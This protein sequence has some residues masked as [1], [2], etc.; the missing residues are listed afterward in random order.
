MEVG[1]LCSA[2]QGARC[3]LLEARHNL[4][5]LGAAWCFRTEG[6]R[7]GSRQPIRSRG[8]REGRRPDERPG[9]GRRHLV[10]NSQVSDKAARRAQ[11]RAASSARHFRM[12]FLP[13]RAKRG[14]E[15]PAGFSRLWKIFPFAKPRQS[16]PVIRGQGQS[17][18]LSSFCAS[19]PSN[20]ESL[21]RGGRSRKSGRLL[22]LARPD[23]NTATPSRPRASRPDKSGSG[24]LPF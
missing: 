15:K 17:P 3:P 23:N 9:R 16:L 22:L 4:P 5:Q 11:A 19:K 7:S 10:D 24:N 14:S 2:G 13:H 12:P 8:P 1:P 20:R 21:P 18:A 6:P